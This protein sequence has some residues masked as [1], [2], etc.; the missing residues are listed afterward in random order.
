[1]AFIDLVKILLIMTTMNQL[2]EIEKQKLQ[3]CINFYQDINPGDDQKIYELS[4]KD[5][6]ENLN[7]LKHDL[8]R[9]LV[10]IVVRMN[11]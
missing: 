2:K 5:L 6:E 9:P 1:M 11:N 10:C 8:K 7:P 3:D 4:L